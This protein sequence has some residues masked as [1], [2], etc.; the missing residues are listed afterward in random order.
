MRS[1]I[2]SLHG[3]TRP[4][5]GLRETLVLDMR[6]WPGDLNIGLHMDNVRYLQLMNEARNLFFQR[7][8]IRRVCLRRRL[9]LPLAS[10]DMRYRRPLHAGQRYRLSTRIVDWDERR[11]EIVQ[12]Y[13]RKGELIAE[14]DGGRVLV[15]AGRN[16]KR[17]DLGFYPPSGDCSAGWWDVSTDGDFLMA[18][19]LL[20]VSESG[21][22][23]DCDGGG[24]LDI[25]DFLCFQDAFTQLDPYADCDGSGTFD[26]F[27][28]LCFQDAFA[29]GCP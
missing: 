8:G 13:E 24:T 17:A 19:A 12:R 29:A 22:Y 16:P 2:R 25:F 20:Y 23:A 6:V 3:L 9:G 28:F 18:N 27:D 5:I 7:T 21:C 1:T 11:F 4:Q 14:G 10:C 26:I 15:D